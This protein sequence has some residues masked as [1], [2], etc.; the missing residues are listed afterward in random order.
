MMSD[1]AKN[2][3]QRELANEALKAVAYPPGTPPKPMKILTRDEMSALL[4]GIVTEHT[5]KL[6]PASNSD[7]D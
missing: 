2:D 1:K 4:P 5:V 6:P 3:R 7:D